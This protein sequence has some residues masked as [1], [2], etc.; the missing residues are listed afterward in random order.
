MA[1][2]RNPGL[3][4]RVQ[5]LEQK[6]GV[7]LHWR[8]GTPPQPCD[9]RFV[10]ALEVYHPL[11]WKEQ[12][13]DVTL[14]SETHPLRQ[15]LQDW[16]HG[17]RIGDLAVVD[18]RLIYLLVDL[19]GLFEYAGG[20]DVN[21][22]FDAVFDVAVPTAVAYVDGYDWSS[23]RD[24]FVT[25]RLGALDSQVRTWRQNIRD[26]DYE[27]DNLTR[28]ITQLVRFNGDL[29]ANIAATEG[30]TRSGRKEKAT[31]DFTALI[32]MM[33]DLVEEVRTDFGRLVVKLKPV[34]IKHEG[35]AYEMGR[36][37]VTF[38]GDSIRIHGD[39]GCEYPHPHVSSDGI[40]CWGNLGP[41][42]GKLLGEGEYA[43][44][45]TTIRSFLSSFNERDAYQEL[46]HWDPDYEPDED[47]E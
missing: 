11:A 25:W 10:P 29:R 9:R 32:K 37:T 33:P 46:H 2:P 42:V 16:T 8:H 21:K 44:L 45:V 41:A 34:S 30:T 28:R 22:L 24:Q 4:A 3:R 17:E 5:F 40:P 39:N 38:D 18:G 35:C 36:Y 27:L 31:A 23:E 47:D 14:G 12:R 26:N 1:H 19:D 7:R 20:V 6:H 13:R 43:A 15:P